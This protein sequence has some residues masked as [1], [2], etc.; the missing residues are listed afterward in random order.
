[1]EELALAEISNFSHMNCHFFRQK[2]RIGCAIRQKILEAKILN[3]ILKQYLPNRKPMFVVAQ[4]IVE[5]P[6]FNA[7]ALQG[8]HTKMCL[9]R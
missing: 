4:I 1:M 5:G 9:F 3:P 6:F 2:L 8:V 7:N